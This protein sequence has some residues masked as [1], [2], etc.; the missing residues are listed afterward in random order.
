MSYVFGTLPDSVYG[1]TATIVGDFSVDADTYNDVDS[2]LSKAMGP[3]WVRFAK[4]GDPN[5]PGLTSWPAFNEDK[6]RYLEFGDSI[7]AKAALAQK[8]TRF[9]VRFHRQPAQPRGGNQQPLERR[10]PQKAEPNNRITDNGG[11]K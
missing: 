10:G 4:T 2:R 7:A 1:T 8:T 3:A 6:E 9:P 11:G 5:G